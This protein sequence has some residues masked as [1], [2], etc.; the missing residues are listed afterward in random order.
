LYTFVLEALELNNGKRMRTHRNLL[1][2]QLDQKVS[3]FE[4]SEAIMVPERGWINAIR[5]TFNMTMEQ[6][7][8][9]LGLTKGAI[10]KIEEREASG[11][12]TLRVL[13]NV[14]EALDMH[15]V[16]GFFPKA[17][18]VDELIDGKA[19]KLARKIVERANQTMKLENQAINIERL[20]ES[21][22]ELA[23]EIKRE[24]RRSLW[25]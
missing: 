9:K 12:I 1:V 6:L 2:K 15:F 7:G 17:G 14:G 16:Y 20:E 24:M 21:I 25:D 19:K 10:Q 18:S 23:S 22:H 4:E 8:R 11:Q 5:T 3:A 13:R